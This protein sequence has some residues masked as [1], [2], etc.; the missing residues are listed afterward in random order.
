MKYNYA[1]ISS[2]VSGIDCSLLHVQCTKYVYISEERSNFDK[3]T[4]CQ[5]RADIFKGF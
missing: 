5:R 4:K 3:F 2:R 1:N